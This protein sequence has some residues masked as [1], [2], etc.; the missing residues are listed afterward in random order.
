MYRPGS[1]SDHI[2]QAMHDL[3]QNLGFCLST[4][5]DERI[6]QTTVT[7]ETMEPIAQQAEAKMLAFVD[8]LNL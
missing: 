1:V 2:E 7:A 8:Q 4:N 6:Q 5:T 3:R